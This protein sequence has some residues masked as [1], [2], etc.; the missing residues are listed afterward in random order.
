MSPV[1]N[2]QPAWGIPWVKPAHLP[3]GLQVLAVW[4]LVLVV[5]AAA[6]GILFRVL[7]S[8]AIVI[9][10]VAVALLIATALQPV[11]TLLHRRTPAG[12]ALSV[13]TAMV[14]L[15]ALLAG[16]FSLFSVRVY[17]QA[18]IIETN[19]LQGYESVLVWLR[20][21]P[22]SLS[23]QDLGA[24][25]TRV[26]DLASKDSSVV[27]GRIFSVGTTTVDVFAGALICVFTT[28]FFLYQ[29]RS[30]WAAVTAFL[31][32]QARE[33]VFQAG[34]RA[35]RSLSAYTRAQVV[36]AAFNGTVL[37][38]GVFVLGAPVALPIG[39]VAFF[40]SFVPLVGVL[41]SGVLPVLVVLATTG[42]VAALAMVAIVIGAHLTESHVLQPFLMGHAVALHPLALLIALA[43]GTLVAGVAGALFAVPLLASLNS[44]GHYLT[45]RDPFP[46]LGSA[47]SSG[48]IIPEAGPST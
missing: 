46:G 2:R 27:V 37:G 17:G 19:A 25:T 8:L 26:A 38:L 33:P 30:L 23:G 11:V 42:P 28:F 48:P 9:I 1:E 13:V 24:L 44:A 18:G 10:P 43:V 16:A 14:G 36:V 12:P 34:R 3:Y 47:P 15:V 5:V 7:E 22:L 45:G 21:G 35:V 41:L 40:A 20:T 32:D 4:S 29:G 6:L 31:P 39:L